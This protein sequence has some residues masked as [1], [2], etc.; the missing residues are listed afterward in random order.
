MD[1]FL[2]ACQGVGLAL[3]VGALAGAP[4]RRD[5]VGVA[6]LVVAIV[7]GAALFGA[8]LAAEDHPAYPGWPVGALLAAFAFLVVRDLAEGAA[9]RAEGGGLTSVLIALGAIA[10][11][12]LSL[13]FGPLALLALAAL[14]WLYLG[15]RT[16]ATR[17]YE[18]LRSLR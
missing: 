9:R 14:L 3:A 18:G 12:G 17:K 15:R 16:R 8:S 11:A 6:L 5:W 10:V 2:A 13:L 1:L 7:G 4:G